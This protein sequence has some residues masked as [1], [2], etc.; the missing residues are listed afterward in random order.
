M[1]GSKNEIYSVSTSRF[2]QLGI[3]TLMSLV[4][5]FA[6]NRY[7]FPGMEHAVVVPMLK[8]MIYP[9][10][11]P[12]D[13]LVDQYVYL[14]SLLWPTIALFIRLI[15]IDISILFA[16]LYSLSLISLFYA[17]Y[18]L[19]YTLFSDS[20]IASLTC[21]ILL[22]NRTFLGGDFFF[23]QVLDTNGFARVLA[24][25]ALQALFVKRYSHSGLLIGC[26]FSLHPLTGTY[27]AGADLRRR[28]QRHP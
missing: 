27:A 3:A 18:S 25:L 1:N 10:L 8:R 17:V 7:H 11:Y 12:G 21:L 5:F 26:C 14:Y 20:R 24:L 22:L 15:P 28:I 13:L 6:I 23:D 16:I 4:S 19:T 2:L 9:E